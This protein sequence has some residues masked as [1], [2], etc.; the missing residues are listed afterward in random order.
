MKTIACSASLRKKHGGIFVPA[1]LA[2]IHQYA[3][4]MLTRC[5]AMILGADS[6]TRYEPLGVM[7]FGEGGPELGPWMLPWQ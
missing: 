3:R 1:N 4:E 7:G 6:Y 2:D 5:G